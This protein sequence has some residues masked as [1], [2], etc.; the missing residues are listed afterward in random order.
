MLDG[1]ARFT[2]VMGSSCKSANK[3]APDVNGTSTAVESSTQPDGQAPA[4]PLS[5]QRPACT[6][7]RRA[8]PG[9]TSSVQESAEHACHGPAST[10]ARSGGLPA[11]RSVSEVGSGTGSD[12]V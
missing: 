8:A 1:S 10:R 12:K 7:M 11:T 4:Q 9:S 2:T 6:V 5:G 3:S